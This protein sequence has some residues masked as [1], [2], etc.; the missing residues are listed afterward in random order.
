MATR[1]RELLN[2]GA[3]KARRSPTK[4]LSDT[5][6]FADADVS[7]AAGSK[8]KVSAHYSGCTTDLIDFADE[9][10]MEANAVT[11]TS[12]EEIRQLSKRGLYVMGDPVNRALLRESDRQIIANRGEV[13]GAELV[14]KLKD[15]HYR[16]QNVAF[17]NRE[18][19]FAPDVPLVSRYAQEL[20]NEELLKRQLSSER[21]LEDLDASSFFN[22]PSA[23]TPTAIE[24][25]VKDFGPK[26]AFKDPMHGR[27]T[28]EEWQSAE[29][30]WE[31][32]RKE[33]QQRGK[34]PVEIWGIQRAPKG[35][36]EALDARWEKEQNYARNRQDLD[37]YRREYRGTQKKLKG[38]NNPTRKRELETRLQELATKGK[39]T[40]ENIK[41]Y[42]SKSSVKPA[43][44]DAPNGPWSLDDM[45]I[46][47]FNSKAE[48]E[49]WI[50]VHRDTNPEVTLKPYKH[51]LPRIEGADAAASGNR[52]IQSLRA[53]KKRTQAKL[54][55]LQKG[56]SEYIV[57]S[58]DGSSWR[59]IKTKD[60]AT[61]KEISGLAPVG[62]KRTLRSEAIT[63]TQRYLKRLTSQ[64]DKKQEM[65]RIEGGTT[66]REYLQLGWSGQNSAVF[67]AEELDKARIFYGNLKK[68]GHKPKFRWL[69][70]TAGMQVRDALA[71]QQTALSTGTRKERSMIAMQID[72]NV[73]YYD[74]HLLP[75]LKRAA[76]TMKSSGHKVRLNHVK[77]DA[78]PTQ[79][80]FA[81]RQQ[82]F[83][84]ASGG[85]QVPFTWP[86]RPDKKDHYERLFSS[87]DEEVPTFVSGK[88]L[89]QHAGGQD[90]RT[91][92]PEIEVHPWVQDFI[93]HKG[94]GV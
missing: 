70:R 38:V 25:S 47:V 41:S 56:S 88:N 24:P 22:A 51:L 6:F 84:Q 49:G 23:D 46:R 26:I 65:L 94:L 40:A 68:A 18:F 29:T 75:T 10:A 1:R 87:V 35:Q 80:M 64:I 60:P 48:A 8:G 5:G 90:F 14:E 16:I 36:L 59:Q 85:E 12:E 72:G 74:A 91:H 28:T 54:A 21:D 43:E 20:R 77:T 63:K 7:P 57:E 50:N 66:G 37:F 45:N 86:I 17:H 42:H 93:D 76:T 62:K 73:W 39:L 32:K 81:V 53:Q 52:T 61:G 55:A 3:V 67:S 34:E 15:E 19:H 27:K 11:L 13:V 33:Q 9:P 83:V 31:G 44:Y 78:E 82:T 30:I 79:A 4:I 69:N 92:F 89:E 2:L 58:P 71:S